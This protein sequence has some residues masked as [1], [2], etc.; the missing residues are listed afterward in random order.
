MYNASLPIYKDYLAILYENRNVPAS[1][2]MSPTAITTASSP[3]HL[4]IPTISPVTEPP[5]LTSFSSLGSSGA[6]GD[7]TR[8]DTDLPPHKKVRLNPPTSQ[9]QLVACL[10]RQVFPHVDSQIATLPKDR[11]NTLAIGKQVSTST[12]TPSLYTV[13][14]RLSPFK[15]LHT[16]SYQVVAILTGQDFSREYGRRGDGTISLEFEAKIAAL[17]ASHVQSLARRLVKQSLKMIASDVDTN[18]H[19]LFRVTSWFLPATP[20]QLRHQRQRPESRRQSQYPTRKPS[21][22]QPPSHNSN[23]TARNHSIRP[24]YPRG[25][26]DSRLRRF[27]F[28]LSR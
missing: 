2:G 11:V 28:L 27:P 6:P 24:R 17:A 16:Y 9:K 22:A 15:S 26:Q 20:P 19:C 14:Y 5:L 10:Q 18:L 12:P 25:Y 13:P 3:T 8:A 23:T 21:R 4:R 1:F 7:L